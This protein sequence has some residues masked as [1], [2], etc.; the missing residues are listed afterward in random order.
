VLALRVQLDKAEYRREFS[1]EVDVVVADRL[2]VNGRMTEGGL[3]FMHRWQV[4]TPDYRIVEASAGMLTAQ[5]DSGSGSAYGGIAGTRLGRGFTRA[6]S[7]ALGGGVDHRDQHLQ[8]AVELARLAQQV[9]QFPE[10]FPRR[11]AVDP[12]LRSAAALQSWRM[13]RAYMPALADSC[14]TYADTCEA[15]FSTR[16]VISH[17]GPG[18]TKPPVGT[19]SAFRRTKCVSIRRLD[20]G[21]G[22]GYVC[23][24]EMEDTLHDLGVSL[25]VDVG[26]T[27]LAASSR[28]DRLPYEGLCE[29]AQQRIGNLVG[30]R[31]EG[32]LT[33]SIAEAVGG[34][35]GCTHLFD[36]ATDCLR[37]FRS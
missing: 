36:L 1:G 24:A 8:L 13:D 18:V 22:G 2:V 34:I 10:D 17:V 32:N 14:V 11:F 19:R 30:R 21:E 9:F 15:L 4:S 25:S 35:T 37:L 6:V 23:H 28:A 29:A 16:D 12:S 20:A 7:A 3:A 27:I 33:A 31:L 26:G 5:D